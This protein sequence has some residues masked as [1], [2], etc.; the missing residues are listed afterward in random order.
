MTHEDA[1]AIVNV[2]R[3]MATTL[4][5]IQL[6]ICIALSVWGLRGGSKCSTKLTR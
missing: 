1:I 2:L 6:T 5:I 4:V 3:Q